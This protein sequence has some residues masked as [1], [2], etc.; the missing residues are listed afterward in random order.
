VSAAAA[1]FTSALTLTGA[2]VNG[3]IINSA[4]GTIGGVQIGTTGAQGSGGVRADTQGFQ[5]QWGAFYGDGANA[6]V[7]QRNPANGV[8][9]SCYLQ[10]GQVNANIYGDLYVR[11]YLRI[12]GGLGVPWHNAGGTHQAWIAPTIY[13]GGDPGA[14][15]FPDGTIWIS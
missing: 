6:Y 4:S 5:S 9:G 15:N 2:T 14:G 10:V 8:Y 3:G 7:R 13:S 11:N 1:T 12:M